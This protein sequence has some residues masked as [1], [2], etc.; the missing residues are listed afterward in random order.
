MRNFVF[1]LGFT[2]IMAALSTTGQTQ[3]ITSETA[4]FYKDAGIPISIPRAPGYVD[5]AAMTSN[6]SK[7][8]LSVPSWASSGKPSQGGL[9]V[10]NS[11]SVGLWGVCAESATA[12]RCSSVSAPWNPAAANITDG[13]DYDPMPTAYWLEPLNGSRITSLT[14]IT[15]TSGTN[16]WVRYY[17]AK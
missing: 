8:T 2:A 17:K 10:F 11:N 14:F 7:V 4:A 16:V 1:A 12:S 15:D 5:R 6:A 9:A 3:T 13:T